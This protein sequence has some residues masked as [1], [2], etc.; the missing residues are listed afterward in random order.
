MSFLISKQSLETVVKSLG[1]CSKNYF[2]IAIIGA[3]STG[4]S[5]LLNHLF[6]T[7]FKVLKGGED[8]KRGERTTRGVIAARDYAQ[9]LLVMDVEGN[10]SYESHVEGDEVR[11]SLF[12]TTKKWY[13]VLLWLAPMSFL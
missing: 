7:N 11:Q 2:T 8:G 6:K 13:Q 3:Q 10:D 5:T 9:L 1:E 4:K 12:R